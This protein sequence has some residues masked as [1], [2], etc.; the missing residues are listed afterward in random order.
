MTPKKYLLLLAITICSTVGD[1]FLKK[2]MNQVGDI[3]VEHPLLLVHALA[4][5]WIIFGVL[6]LIGFFSSYVSSLS[7]ADLTYVMPATA[8]GYVLTALSSAIFLHEHVS[9]S[10]WAGVC[11]ITLAV[12]F[13]TR[14]PAKTVKASSSPLVTE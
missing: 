14:G 9:V 3:S 1:L 13:V 4:N 2:G 10:R 11:L 5:P 6:I 12:G 7:W 8:F